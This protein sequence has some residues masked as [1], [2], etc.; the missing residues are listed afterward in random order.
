MFDD[1]AADALRTI[2]DVPA[3][4]AN[5][6][7]DQVIR[8]GRRRLRA[9][10]AGAAAGLAAVAALVAGISV[11][12]SL[13]GAPD[14]PSGVDTAMSRQVQPRPDLS[15]WTYVEEVQLPNCQVLPGHPY[16]APPAWNTL[17]QAVVEAVTS[18]TGSRFE[19]LPHNDTVADNYSS[20]LD[21]KVMTEAEPVLLG[22]SLIGWDGDPAEEAEV[23]EW[24]CANH[25]QKVLPNGTIM[26]FDPLADPDLSDVTLHVLLPG[27]HNLILSNIAG[28]SLTG[29]SPEQTITDAGDLPF[30]QLVEVADALSRS[31][32]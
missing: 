30:P 23:A 10:K 22:I 31:G 6:T 20:R 1:E 9:R 3:P 13:V 18:A 16:Q 29:I 11:G 7:A 14:G 27:G 26:W 24:S 17:R 5:T 32:L 28:I 12:A 2:A 8:L 15:D 19:I 21:G 25:Y 4:P